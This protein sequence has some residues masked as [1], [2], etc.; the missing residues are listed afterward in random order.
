MSEEGTIRSIEIIWELVDDITSPV[1]KIN[2]R[3]NKM[4]GKSREIIE[5]YEETVTN[6]IYE[7]ARAYLYAQEAL[8]SYIK[9]LKSCSN[10]TGV[11]EEVLEYMQNPPEFVFSRHA[12]SDISDLSR[13]WAAEF[14]EKTPLNP[15]SFNAG[16]AGGS[17]MM[18]MAGTDM[19]NI[20]KLQAVNSA[21][22]DSIGLYREFS[23]TM[24]SVLSENPALNDMLTGAFEQM[25]ESLQGIISTGGEAGSALM[26][27]TE[28]VL[29]LADSAFSVADEWGQ[30]YG[31]LTNYIPASTFATITTGGLSGAMTTLGTSL[32]AIA[33]NP[34]TYAILAI[35]AAAWL[36][37][38]VFDKGW[39]NSMLKGA[40]DWIFETFP[41]LTPLVEGIV[42]AFTYLQEVMASVWE[43]IKP[44]VDIITSTLENPVVKTVL[45]ALWSVTPM[46]MAENVYAVATGQPTRLQSD[47]EDLAGGEYIQNAY[48]TQE[49]TDKAYGSSAGGGVTVNI[50]N[51]DASMNT[52]DLKTEG[53][54][55]DD[56]NTIMNRRDR[57]LQSGMQ[58]MITGELV[59][60]G[61]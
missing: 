10:Y 13:Q 5:K 31:I 16:I 11:S 46:G 25:P 32:W 59:S 33:A 58:R 7:I 24:A 29:P 43:Y 8:N 48:Q 20:E 56:L 60:V 17:G 1:E 39:E 37:W 61:A 12:L 53:V 35:V 34:V 18:L 27:I 40:I 30:V 41:W 22:T 15:V 28:S 21:I 6:S 47:F 2:E 50:G 19:T 38:D 44:I 51:V 57:N 14:E 49:I 26:G 36:L 23:D 45:D 52:G 42:T 9:D 4:I 55:A 3:I 54:T